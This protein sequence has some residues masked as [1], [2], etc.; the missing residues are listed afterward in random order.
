MPLGAFRINSLA[1]VQAVAEPEVNPRTEGFVDV[2]ADG[3]AQLTN[4]QYKLRSGPY[5]GSIRLGANGDIIKP[6]RTD[7]GDIMNDGDYTIEAFVR[8]DS[9]ASV[10]YIFSNR[11]TTFGT[12]GW[13]LSMRGDLAGDK[14][15]LLTS[16]YTGITGS[17][18]I[19]HQNGASA[20]TWYHVALV[21]SGNILTLYVDGVASTTTIDL[22]GSSY[23]P[24]DQLWFGS[25]GNTAAQMIGYMDEIRVSNVA[26]Y[27]SDFTPTTTNF[28]PD[29]NTLLLLH[30]D[31]PYGSNGNYH[32]VDDIGDLRPIDIA[33]I[34]NE[35]NDT[36]STA[37]SISTAQSKFGGSSFRSYDNDGHVDFKHPDWGSQY[38]IEFWFRTDSVSGTQYIAGQWGGSGAGGS[39]WLIYLSGSTLKCYVNSLSSGFILNNVTIA[40]GVTTNTWHHVAISWDG[41]THRTFYNGTMGATA[42]SSLTPL[43]YESMHVWLGTVSGTTANWTGYIDEFRMS[44]TARYTS[45]FTVQS[46]AHANDANTQV[47]LHFDGTNGSTT[48]TDDASQDYEQAVTFDGS[49]DY[50]SHT[51]SA[52]F[53]DGK[54]LTVSMWFRPATVHTARIYEFAN[55]LYSQAGS[56]IFIVSD[57]RIRWGAR[58]SSN[59]YVMRFDILSTGTKAYSAN[60]WYHLLGSVDL[61]S[62]S[63]R[64]F[65]LN[66][67]AITNPS[68]G[69]WSDYNNDNMDLTRNTYAIGSA[70]DFSN[71]FN[72]DLGPLW[73]DDS[74]IDLSVESN[75]RKFIS[76]SGTPVDAG[77]DGSTPTGSQP[78]IYIKGGATTWNSATQNVGSTSDFT[79]TGS[80]TDSSNEPVST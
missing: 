18:S 61:T 28:E 44:D 47:L 33:I 71:K 32:I 10:D 66:E 4:A 60:T 27:T 14:F 3:N 22:S 7:L 78:L 31:G 12:F 58:N 80:V 54:Q 5:G 46:T 25:N 73:I 11:K 13:V 24:S 43:Y 49:S 30:G 19:Q 34:P 69:T 57:G 17:T 64:H 67:V 8:H 68:D 74:Y 45:S 15:E 56:E 50:L 62:T 21:R 1:K 26:R 39:A 52:G 75:R 9:V 40:S 41:S 6:S 36:S 29:E 70:S 35:T 38:T 37:P 72:G 63:T 23:A 65:Y 20:D 16:G 79:M 53:T 77:S 51:S 42:S 55:A 59:N 48:T 76:S 2:T